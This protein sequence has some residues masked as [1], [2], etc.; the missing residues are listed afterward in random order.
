MPVAQG[1]R[2]ANST[3]AKYAKFDLEGKLKSRTDVLEKWKELNRMEDR[4]QWPEDNNN[5]RKVF[6]RLSKTHHPD[7]ATGSADRF[8]SLMYFKDK[9]DNIYHPGSFN[10][11]GEF[12]G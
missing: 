10:P 5:R 2:M 8:A 1:M 11:P 6:M 7:K 3:I 9:A 4:F 12:L